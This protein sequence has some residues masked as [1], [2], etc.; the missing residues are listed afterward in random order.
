MLKELSKKQ[1]KLIKGLKQSK[2]ARL[3][4]RCFI[5]EGLKNVAESLKSDYEIRYIVASEAFFEL[6][7]GFVKKM[8]GKI[9]RNRLYQVSDKVFYELSDTVTP[10][11][12][13]AV[14][15]IKNTDIENI[16]KE[17]FLIIALDRIQDP[18]NMGTII[19]TADAAGA[20]AILIGKGCVDIYNPKVVRSAMGS[21]FH[22][23]FVQTDDLIKT[24]IMLK[25]K[26]GK[27]VT[28]H[29]EAQKHYYNVN[30]KT[31]TVIVM[32]SE[33][34]GVSKE[35][36]NISDELIRIPMPGK[37]ESLNVAIAHGIIAFE[38]VRQRIKTTSF[39][40]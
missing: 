39:H 14:I 40:L 13:L 9:P 10:Q 21:L 23:P 6:N 11:G 17:N 24:L 36:A 4:N 32:G 19:R 15:N 7:D 3:K 27:I 1:Q 28:T 26:G 12:I 31:G 8:A 18:G 38:V 16:L 20:D 5:V 29:L 35:I 2:N 25:E 34:E 33:D 22:M 37:A 30:Y